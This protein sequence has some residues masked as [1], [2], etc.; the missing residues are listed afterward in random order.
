MNVRL[1]NN[2]LLR[3]LVLFISLHF[4]SISKAEDPAKPWNDGLLMAG[5]AFSGV[6][7][8]E[9]EKHS[10][11]QVFARE[12][13]EYQAIHRRQGHQLWEKRFQVI[14]R[15]MGSPPTEICAESW[16]WE[17][18]ADPQTVGQSMFHA[19]RKSSG[20]WR[21]ASRPCRYYGAAMARGA[22]GIW[23][24]CIIVVY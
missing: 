7:V 8:F 14:T 12:H 13:A 20:H 5:K 18:D 4:I 10:E 6:R 17:K 2:I 1:H 19:W 24:A 15:A 9:G 22:N 21:V 3:G 16:P 23:Y 11:L